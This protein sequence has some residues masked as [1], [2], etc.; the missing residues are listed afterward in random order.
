MCPPQLLR[1]LGQ[2]LIGLN[3]LLLALRPNE[4]LDTLA[5][6]LQYN[7]LLLDIRLDKRLGTL[8]HLDKRHWRSK[9]Q[10]VPLKTREQ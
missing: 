9:P 4:R 6:A 2:R 10:P 1:Q 7:E 5:L 3:E 8:S